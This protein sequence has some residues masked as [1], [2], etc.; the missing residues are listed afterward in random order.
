MNTELIEKN[1]ILLK[2]QV[3]NFEITDMNRYLECMSKGL[4]DKLFFL[5]DVD[6][7]VLIDFG[8]ADGI[9][10]NYISKVKPNW[11]LLGY[12]IDEK[13]IEISRNK[14]SH[15]QF[16]SDWSVVEEFIEENKHLKIGIFLSS[17]IHEVY[18]YSRGK[19]IDFFWN[20]QIFHPNV[21]YVIIRDMMALD[22]YNEMSFYDVNK[23]REKSNIYKLK[24]FE[25]KWG[26]IDKNY[27]NLL[28]WLLKYKYEINWRREVY[29][30]YL[31]ITLEYLKN[32]C[33]PDEWYIE[34]EDH[35]LYEYIK[36]LIKTDFDIDLVEPTHLKMI[37]KNLNKY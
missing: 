22:I 19:Q 9:S 30:N 24:D 29:E 23:V 8:S 7:D 17:V 6:L 1:N 32:N 14:Y 4:S 13:M 33:I 3:G 37:I 35:Y 21:D 31:P 2:F 5:N 20:E 11:K 26:R 18:S 28:H 27:R 34:F 16:E 10:L 25:A 36:N 12:D 15:I